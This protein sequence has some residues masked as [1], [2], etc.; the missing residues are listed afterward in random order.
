[1][2]PKRVA[3]SAAW[4][5]ASGQTPIYR[6]KPDERYVLLRAFVGMRIRVDI[7]V[8]RDGSLIQDVEGELVS[9][10]WP[11]MGTVSELVI[12][13]RDLDN[14]RTRDSAYSAARVRRIRPIIPD[15]NA[16]EG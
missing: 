8:H 14:G 5:L 4:K 6:M 1:V 3:T 10:A 11:A 7:D 13:R 9:V 15:R 12:L 2:K 16:K